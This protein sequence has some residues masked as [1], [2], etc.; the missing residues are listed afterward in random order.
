MNDPF[1][2]E[3][4]RRQWDEEHAAARMPFAI[5]CVGRRKARQPPMSPD[6]ATELRLSQATA[7][8]LIK[9]FRGGGTSL[10]RWLTV[11]VGG[12]RGTASWTRSEKKSSAR[13]YSAYYLKQTRPTVSQLVRDVQ[14]TACRRG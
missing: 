3:V 13:R 1:P 7:Y 12:Q 6:L 11:N 14:Q 5:S 2:D 9:M 10:C 8:R 4:D